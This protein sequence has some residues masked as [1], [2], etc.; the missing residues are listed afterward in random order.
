MRLEL[1]KTIFENSVE[2]FHV[3]YS[4]YKLNLTLNCVLR[5][6]LSIEVTLSAFDCGS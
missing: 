5:I 3:K 6:F 1:F 4:T 2:V